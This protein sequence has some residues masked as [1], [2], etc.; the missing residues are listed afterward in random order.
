MI[1]DINIIIP[2]MVANNM[3]DRV[4]IL[5][6][7]IGKFIKHIF[8]PMGPREFTTYLVAEAYDFQTVEKA[9]EWAEQSGFP[10]LVILKQA[11]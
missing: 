5:N 11:P 8:T 3:N 4:V 2:V 6:Q 9:Q 7:T 1:T 10:N